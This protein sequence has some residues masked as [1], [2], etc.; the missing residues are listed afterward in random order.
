MIPFVTV[1]CPLLDN[2]LTNSLL[3]G[4][5]KGAFTGANETTNGYVAAANN[6]ILSSTDIQTVID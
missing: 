3:F 1:N 5:K 4:H 6:G 2:D